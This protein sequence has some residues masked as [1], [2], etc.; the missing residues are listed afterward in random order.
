MSTNSSIAVLCDDGSIIQVFC[1]WD[2]S[3]EHNGRLLFEN[4]NNRALAEELAMKGDLFSL[5]AT[6]DKCRFQ[7]ALGFTGYNHFENYESYYE[8]SL[9][10]DFNQEFNYYFDEHGIWNV[11]EKDNNHFYWLEWQLIT[12]GDK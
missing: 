8:T 12:E 5:G 9:E 7:D 4:Y 11:R 2:G 3:V 1:H 6:L 10:A